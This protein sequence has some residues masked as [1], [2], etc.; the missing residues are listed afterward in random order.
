MGNQKPGGAAC[1]LRAW[2]FPGEAAFVCGELG[3]PRA[4]MYRLEDRKKLASEYIGPE[5]EDHVGGQTCDPSNSRRTGRP[6]RSAP[7]TGPC[8]MGARRG[9]AR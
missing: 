8:T 4:T 2:R 9:D 6:S 3:L 1:F 5:T 7:T